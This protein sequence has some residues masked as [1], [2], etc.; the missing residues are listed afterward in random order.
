MTP[1]DSKPAQSNRVNQSA[2]AI[3]PAALGGSVALVFVSIAASQI[4]LAA[5][6]ALAV[7]QWRRN[8]LRVCRLPFLWPLVYLL[9]WTV[10]GALVSPGS[11]LWFKIIKKYFVYALLVLVPCVFSTKIERLLAV[12]RAIFATSAVLAAAG[13]AQLAASPRRDLLHRISGF[14]SHWMTYS[15]LLML[16][17][18]AL[19]AYA[20][21]WRQK[22]PWWTIAVAVLLVSGL[23]W[24]QTRNAWLGS[25]AG[26]ATVAML[27]RPR[28]VAPVAVLLVGL[29]IVSPQEVKQRLRSGLDLNDP[30]TRN[31]IELFETSVRL[32]RHNAWF[33]VGPRV[34]QEALRYRGTQ[35][36]PDWMYQHMHNNFLQIAAERGIP[37]LMFW[38]WLIARLAW[39]AGRVFRNATRQE[40]IGQ[41]DLRHGALVASTAALA[42]CAALLVA[43][44]F[45]Y[46]FGD[47]EVLTLFV[48]LTGAPYAFLTEPALAEW[49]VSTSSG[50][51]S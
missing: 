14:M 41:L 19:T 18:V 23:Y 10:M 25:L 26:I 31:R 8:R 7:W 1:Q 42:A 51:A 32:I 9:A 20:I 3:L 5:S 6:I 50:A 24:S 35:E 48:F 2:E 4:L 46:N 37:G 15:G 27:R 43:G 33:G 39:D 16:A 28:A 12:Y 13:L 29:Y 45:E 49:S 34:G 47:S 21:C 38:L 44:I 17:L 30:N 36:F 11:L 40:R 22:R